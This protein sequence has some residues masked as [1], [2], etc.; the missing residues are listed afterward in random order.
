MMTAAPIRKRDVKALGLI[1]FVIVMKIILD[2]GQCNP[3]HNALKKL[4]AEAG[5]E[6]ERIKLPA[7]AV[8][9]LRE[10]KF[11]LVFV[12]RKIDADYTDGLELVKAMQADKELKKIPIMLISNYTEAQ[13]EAVKEGAV[14]GFG[15]AELKKPETLEK[16]K[17]VLY[18]SKV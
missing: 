16:V 4:A 5:A 18:G 13:E 2:V 10:K 14:L 1:C 8:E 15:K 3:D 11:D 7:Q 12:N 9:R 6:V 17:T